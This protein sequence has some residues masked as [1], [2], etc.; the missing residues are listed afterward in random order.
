MAPEP[1]VALAR[2]VG[3]HALPI[4]LVLL[5]LLLAVTVGW[6]AWHAQMLPRMQ[7]RLPAPTMVLIHAAAGF[8]IVMAGAVLFAEIARHMEPEGS[9]ALADEA[10]TAAL[11][12]L[13][14][15]TTLQVFAA[16][17]HL[18]DVL[19]LSVL[20]AAVALPLWRRRR[21]RHTLALGWMLAL[22]GNALL[23]PALKTIFERVRPMREHGML[24]ET[25]FSFPSGHSSGATVADG[26]LAYLAL[27]TLAPRWHLPALVGATAL[28]YAAG[29]S[30]VF[31][32]L[33]FASD[34]AAG[35]ASGAAW[36][37][38]CILSRELGRL[39]RRFA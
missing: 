1:A 15:P 18:G 19:T 4:F 6:W 28:V 32:Q 20:G 30:R 35:F 14:G 11:R 2:Q 7:R 8:A 21:R 29:C 38:V 22:A 9:V 12:S 39:Y 23:N 17:T 10:L 3:A 36:L 13:I 27:R 5:G 16:L 25:G 34:V 33:H 26:M 31:L 37:T 24:G